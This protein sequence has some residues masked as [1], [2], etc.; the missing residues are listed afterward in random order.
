VSATIP[1]EIAD[2][3][4]AMHAIARTVS[5]STPLHDPARKTST[6]FT[7][8]LQALVEQGV[9]PYRLAKVLGI[10]AGSI[11]QRLARHGYRTPVP[12]AA[13]K[14]YRGTSTYA[15]RRANQGR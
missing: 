2:R 8:T 4:R 11:R 12:S 9:T 14:T 7:A 1:P 10:G 15:G 3:L 5:G 13:H 6:E